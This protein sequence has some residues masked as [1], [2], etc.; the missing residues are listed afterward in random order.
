MDYDKDFQSA[1]GCFFFA[2]PKVV[3]SILFSLLNRPL[4]GARLL[5][6]R[7]AVGTESLEMED[8]RIDF[9]QAS[10]VGLSVGNLDEQQEPFLK[11]LLLDMWYVTKASGS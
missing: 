2:S 1:S 7:H 10:W 9:D 4:N 3:V 5:F 8:A 6:T 11:H